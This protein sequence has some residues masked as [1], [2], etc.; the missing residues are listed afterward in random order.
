MEFFEYFSLWYGVNNLTELLGRDEFREVQ[1]RQL[2]CLLDEIDYRVP[3]AKWALTIETGLWP[4]E[5]EFFDPWEVY[6]SLDL[7]DKIEVED[8]T[9]QNSRQH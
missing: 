8:V 4:S 5:I 7:T 6:V 9:I 1:G 3:V 2:P